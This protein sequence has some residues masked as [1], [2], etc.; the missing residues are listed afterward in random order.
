M[1]QLTDVETE[2]RRM[3]EALAGTMEGKVCS[4]AAQ[5]VMQSGQ[6][7]MRLRARSDLDQ[8]PI[9]HRAARCR[10]CFW[11]LYDGDWCQNPNCNMAGKSVGEA[12]IHMSNDEAQEAIK[13]QA[14]VEGAKWWEW[15]KEGATM[16]PVDRRDTEAE[17]TRRYTKGA[18]QK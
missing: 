7:A 15:Q 18:K 6:Q 3:A 13:V 16:W 8:Q 10:R 17:A 5:I 1:S 11:A 2:L 9:P 12:R 4:L 14:F